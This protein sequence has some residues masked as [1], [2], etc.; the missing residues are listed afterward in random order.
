ME[1]RDKWQWLGACLFC[2][3]LFVGSCECSGGE[4]KH[5]YTKEAKAWK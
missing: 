5:R 3:V 1:R 4:D 2:V